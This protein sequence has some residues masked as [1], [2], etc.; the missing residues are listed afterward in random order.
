MDCTAFKAME[1]GDYV[2]CVWFKIYLNRKSKYSVSL[3]HYDIS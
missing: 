1:E 2:S 3:F